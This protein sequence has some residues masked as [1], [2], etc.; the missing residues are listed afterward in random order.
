MPNG[1]FSIQTLTGRELAAR[2][3]SATPMGPIEDWP[4]SLRA[5]LAMMLSCPTPMFLAWG[6][7]LRCFYNDAYRPLLGHRVGMA[8]GE[9]FDVVWATIWDELLPLVERTMAGGHVAATDMQLD[10]QRTGESEES[11]W[12]FTYSPAFDDHGQVAGL[13]C[14]TGETTGRVMAERERAAADER[15]QQALSAGRNIGAWDWDVQNDV[16]RA[17]S[18]FALL[19]GVDPRQAEQGASIDRFF[20]GVHPDDLQAAQRAIAAAMDPDGDGTFLAEYRLL[21]ADGHSRWVSAQGR[22]VF[23]DAGRPVRFPG[24]SYDIDDRK[25]A[26]L[27]ALA[28][29]AER[30]F[31]LSLSARQR[32][33]TDPAAIMRFTAQALGERLGINRAGFARIIGHRVR[34]GAGWN[35]GALPPLVGDHS[36]DRFGAVGT[37][38]LRSGQPIVSDDFTTDPAFDPAVAAT[39]SARSGIVIP[40]RHDGRVEAMLILNHATPRRWTAGEVALATE[41]AEIGWIAVQRADALR[42]LEAKVGRQD[43]QL[44]RVATELHDAASARAAAETQVRQLQKME[45]VGQL[46]GGIAHDFNNMLA[47]VIGSLDMID[48]RLAQG[49]IDV[50]RYVEAAREGADRAAALTQRLLAF[51]RQSPLSPEPVEGNRLIADLTDLLARTLGERIAV[52]TV[53]GAGLWRAEADRGQLENAIVN[54]AV[55]ARDAMEDGGKLTIETANAHVGDDYAREAEMAAGQ[56]VLIAVSDTGSGMA[57]DVLAKAFDPFFTTKPVGRG[58]GLGLSQVFGFVRQSRGHVRLYSEP[59]VGTTVR[60]YLPRFYGE[61]PTPGPRTTLPDVRGGAPS[62]VVLVVEDEAR[63]RAFSVEVLRDLGYRVV[64]AASGPEALALIEGG[65]PVSL[66][67]TDVVMPGMTGRELAD[68][69]GALRPGLRVLYTTGYTRNAVVHNGVLDPGTR[70]LSKPFGVDELARKVRE[71]LDG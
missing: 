69:A 33:A 28:A 7:D 5:L 41:I 19:Y 20:D 38:L 60:L 11:W 31:V 71:A 70:L 67:F 3:W 6:P 47:I 39:Y 42:Q 50:T 21:G 37:A 25:R 68:R 65:Q 26:E 8:L 16:V 15:L 29:K 66:L 12:S 64:Q 49:R 24:V 23:D 58:T 36:L 13:L 34:Y 4:V 62:E 10:L 57:P 9:R 35:D 52:E 40:L 63:V 53:L 61:A 43:A 56:Y 1:P 59:G 18:R 48:R 22:C 51:S 44:E 55:N 17:D 27:A 32:S 45:A 30:D 2:D 54:L 14:I 46:T